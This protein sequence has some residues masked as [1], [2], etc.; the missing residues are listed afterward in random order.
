MEA[1]KAKKTETT[2]IDSINLTAEQMEV[3]KHILGHAY[4]SMRWYNEDLDP[5]N[6]VW[7]TSNYADK[8]KLTNQQFIDLNKILAII[9]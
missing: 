4:E 7:E 2:T 9:C 1:T 8:L 5:K 6:R 3:I